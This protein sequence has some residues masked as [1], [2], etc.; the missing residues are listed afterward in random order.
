MN[1]L[2]TAATL[3]EIQPAY[4]FLEQQYPQLEEGRFQKGSHQIQVLI[5]GVGTLLCSYG[6]TR[7]LTSHSCDLAVQAGI[8]GSFRQDLLLGEVVEVEKEILGDLG[9]QDGE[10]FRDLFDIRLMEEG[11]FPFTG[12]CLWNQGSRHPLFPAL[13]KVRGLT[14][15]QVSGRESTISIWKEKYQ[16]DLE[17]MEGAAF[18]FVC[19]E[20]KIPFL[21]LR[22]ISNEVQVRDPSKWDIPLAVNHLNLELIGLLSRFGQY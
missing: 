8:A 20:E 13:R 10:N 19:L 7:F 9:V 17:T 2:L 5:T 14:V 1:L 12:K 4:H 11:Q 16:P 15:N 6:L 18:H 22:C 3:P 21:Q